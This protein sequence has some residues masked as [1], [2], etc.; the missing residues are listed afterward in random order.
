MLSVRLILLMVQG[1]P[2]PYSHF[3]AK[4]TET[5]SEAETE[6]QK[7][8]NWE[9]LELAV[10]PGY[11]QPR[12]QPYPASLMDPVQAGVVPSN[13]LDSL[14]CWHWPMVRD[15]A[16][17]PGHQQSRACTDSLPHGIT[18]SRRERPRD[19]TWRGSSQ[20]RVVSDVLSSACPCCTLPRLPRSGYLSAQLGGC[21]RS[22]I[23]TGPPEP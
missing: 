19:W 1:Q 9:G 20:H 8:Q 17:W 2:D 12:P 7:A 5:P 11:P 22:S 6:T 23:L 14:G 4:E 3:T 21:W 16:C 18:H 10:D 15:R 13:R